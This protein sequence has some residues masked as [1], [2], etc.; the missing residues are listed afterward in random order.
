MA[1]HDY[2]PFVRRRLWIVSLLSLFVFQGSIF[3]SGLN[4]S[5]AADQSTPPSTDGG[6]KTSKADLPAAEPSVSGT[7]IDEVLNQENAARGVKQSPLPPVSDLAF[8]RRVSLDLIGRIPTTAEIEEFTAWPEAERRTLI[9]D[10]LMA[11]DRF[12]DRWTTFY[13]DLLRLRS[14]AEGG[15]AAIAYIHRSLADDVPYDELCRQLISKNGKAGAVPEVGFILGD[16][17]DPMAMAGVTAQVFLGIR[18]ACAQCHDH[19]FDVWKREDFYGL[20]AFF[21]KTRRVENQFTRTIYTTEAGE[22]LVLW[23]PEGVGKPEDRKPMQPRFPFAM[24]PEDHPSVVRLNARRK[25][26][27]AEKEKALL[28]QRSADVDADDVLDDLLSDA[29][30]KVERRTRT[31][32]VDE[33]LEEARSEVRKIG[34][35]GGRNMM[36]EWRTELAEQIT[37]PRNRYFSRCFTN[38]VW[39]ELIGRGFVNPLDDFNQSNPPSHPQS[40]DYLADEFV[41]N[42]YD[43]KTLVR[44]IVTSEVYRRGHT[45]VAEESLRTELEESF[46]ALPHRRMNSEALY[47]SVVTAGHLFEVK[48]EVGK[49]MKTVWT[50]TR[51]P[52][53]PGGLDA[54]L[55][56]DDGKTMKREMAA[57]DAGDE[58]LPGYNLESAIELDFDALLEENPDDLAAENDGEEVEVERMRAM[59]KEEIEAE[60]MRMQAR[61][62]AFSYIER[63]VRQTI[64]DNPSFVSSFRMASP[65]DPEHFLRVFGQPDREQ[66]GEIR[67]HAPSMR[68]ALMLLNGRLSHEAARVGE[69]EPIYECLI[70][71]RKNLE[72][73]VELAYVEI[74]TRE[75]TGEERAEAVEI[76]KGAEN[77]LDGVA[78]LRWVLLNCNEFRFVP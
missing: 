8:I 62:N 74:L 56:D 64:D 50:E 73:A 75:P 72:K 48:H 47:D 69:M 38:R 40:L 68:Q 32:A 71:P 10:K 17:A 59:S 11:D 57:N 5:L 45:D 77:P 3:Q 28:V 2:R 76:V 1:S 21:G 31:D 7:S 18:V 66:L 14:N 78:D 37:S 12:V 29:D 35:A 58:P 20:A 22:T 52:K 33:S 6:S 19:P 46:L 39:N 70:G 34:K 25:A 51:V 27:A 41:A 67:D 54:K 4:H 65:A 43:L 36:S 53:Q 49:N 60:R 55:G 61:Q 9:V 16:G 26:L 42:G 44:T 24:L 30:K 13:A 23:P 63:F 15:A